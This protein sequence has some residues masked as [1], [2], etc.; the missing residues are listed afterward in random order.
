MSEF[1]KGY[2]C[3]VANL[4]RLHDEPTLARDILKENPPSDY[5]WWNEIDVSDR[6][7]ILQNF[8]WPEPQEKEET[9]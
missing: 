4:L 2:V 1:D 3:A 9:K 6:T 8:D 7:I 5:D